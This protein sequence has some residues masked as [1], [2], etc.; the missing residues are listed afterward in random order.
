MPL[1]I[2]ECFSQSPYYIWNI[3]MSSTQEADTTPS[4]HRS[5][6]WLILQQICL[7]NLNSPPHQTPYSVILWLLQRAELEELK[8]MTASCKKLEQ[9]F[10]Q[11]KM[12]SSRNNTK[13]RKIYISTVVQRNVLFIDIIS[14]V[15]YEMVYNSQD[16]CHSQSCVVS[17]LPCHTQNI[18]L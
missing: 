14:C 1:L 3:H 16:Y 11:K 7:T 4:Y 18:I 5:P 2:T 10:E 15:Y 17:R 9:V 6:I 12:V 8:A 13:Y